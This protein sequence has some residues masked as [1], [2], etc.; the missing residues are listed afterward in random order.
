MRSRC[1]A[2]VSRLGSARERPDPASRDRRRRRG[3]DR[4]L[5][6]GLARRTSRP[7]ARRADRAATS[8]A[9]RDRVAQRIAET[10][11]TR[12]P[13]STAPSPAS[14]WSP[15]T[16]PSRCTSTGRSG[17]P[18][19]RRCCSTEAERQIAAGGH[20]VAFL[21]VVRGNDRAQAF[22][23]QA[24]LD[25]RGRRRLP[26]DRPSAR[27]SSRRAGSSPSACADS[28]LLARGDG[29]SDA[30]DR[31]VDRHAVVLA[32]VA[33][34]ERRPHRPRR[35]WSPAITM[36]GTFCSWALR[37]FFCIRSSDSSTSTRIPRACI[38]F[39]TS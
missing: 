3:R 7:G 30:L 29:R 34:A 8:E 26:G 11:E 24:G 22:Y 33:V 38:R 5:P 35:R 39:A 28:H 15:A 1:I 9:F 21:A 17:A 2:P 13:R 20:D 18:A 23:A 19:S 31:L 37:I 27:T 32:S 12:S 10:D 16:R 14:S 6:R 36:N 4:D 25:R